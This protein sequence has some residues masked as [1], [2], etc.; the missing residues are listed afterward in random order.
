MTE[1]KNSVLEEKNCNCP[2][3]KFLK[4]DCT[5]K[6]FAVVLASFIGC[7]L[8]ILVF[9]PK[10]HQ[11]PPRHHAPYMRVIDRPL[12][13]PM[14]RHRVNP[15]FRS[16]CPCREIHIYKS[17]APRHPQFKKNNC[18]RNFNK[19]CDKNFKGEKPIIKKTPTP[20]ENK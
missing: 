2:V 11:R 18:P 20:V 3:C 14:Y 19:R 13:P 5:K 4:S 17:E 8:A 15:D 6:F 1:E 10:K 9:A 7:S 16:K 12:P